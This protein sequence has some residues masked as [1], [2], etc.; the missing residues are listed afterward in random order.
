MDDKKVR[1]H[2]P[3]DPRLSVLV[4]SAGVFHGHGLRRFGWILDSDLDLDLD[5]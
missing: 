2:V 1:M 5:L 3:M 4:S